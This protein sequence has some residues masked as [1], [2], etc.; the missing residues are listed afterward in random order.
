MTSKKDFG[1]DSL[2]LKPAKKDF[3]NR[4]KFGLIR[5]Y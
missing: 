5:G 4:C 3:P 2:F 1:D